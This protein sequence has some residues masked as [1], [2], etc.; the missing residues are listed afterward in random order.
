MRS[1]ERR[2][3]CG[4]YPLMQFVPHDCIEEKISCR[5]IPL[6]AKGI[7]VDTFYRIGTQQEPQRATANWLRETIRRLNQERGHPLARNALSEAGM[8]M[9]AAFE[10]LT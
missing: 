7:H 1:S 10:M 8:N 3:P 5:H 2:L 9:R 6:N 4:E